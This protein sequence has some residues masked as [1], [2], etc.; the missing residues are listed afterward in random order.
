[1][2]NGDYYNQEHPE[3]KK[4]NLK[5]NHFRAPTK[6]I[7][8]FWRSKRRLIRHVIDALSLILILILILINNYLYMYMYSKK[9]TA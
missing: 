9:N 7:I 3:Q 4:E 6:M 8:K 1:M 2:Q 5:K